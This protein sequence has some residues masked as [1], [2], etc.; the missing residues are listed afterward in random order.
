MTGISLDTLRSTGWVFDINLSKNSSP[1]AFYSL[2]KFHAVNWKVL[3]TTL[4][5]QVAM[6]IEVVQ[7]RRPGGFPPQPARL[8]R[9]PG[10]IPPDTCE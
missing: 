9:R 5:E 6:V 10:G 2:Y 8:Y 4:M 1:F 7:P 3:K